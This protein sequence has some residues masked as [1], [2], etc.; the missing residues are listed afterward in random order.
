MPG[1]LTYT[2]IALLVRD[3]LGQMRD[4]LEARK[5]AGIPNGAMERQVLFLAQVA[6]EIVS[7]GAPVPPPVRVY[8]PPL[9]DQVSRFFFAGAVGPEFTAFAAFHAPGQQWLRDTIHK[10]SP[11]SNRELVVANSTQFM[12]QLLQLSQV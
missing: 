8:G 5:R 10:G 4:Q 11:D 1:A 12:L 9:G 2:A 7:A 3:R 6:H